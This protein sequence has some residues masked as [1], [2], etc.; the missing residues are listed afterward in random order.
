MEN[1]TLVQ[2]CGVRIVDYELDYDVHM[3]QDL[4]DRCGTNRNTFYHPEL[5]EW[6]PLGT[7]ATHETMSHVTFTEVK[8]S[9]IL[10]GGYLYEVGDE[11]ASRCAV[12][13]VKSFLASQFTLWDMPSLLHERAQHATVYV[14]GPNNTNGMFRF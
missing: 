1:K 6:F 8:D 9:G 4:Q 7:V 12:K 13:S 14:P 2:Y 3:L 5:Q 11:M 10:V